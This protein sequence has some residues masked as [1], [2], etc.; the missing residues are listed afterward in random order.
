MPV[1]SV[2]IV[3]V[4]QC[5]FSFTSEWTSGER[6]SVRLL[7]KETVLQGRDAHSGQG[8]VLAERS[9]QVLDPQCS[10]PKARQARISWLTAM[11][12][13][14]PCF[15]SMRFVAWDQRRTMVERRNPELNIGYT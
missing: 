5:A 1:A 13:H 3:F 2:V 14:A 7:C 4:L 15:D 12:F 11:A 8:A 6:E 10:Q 9:L